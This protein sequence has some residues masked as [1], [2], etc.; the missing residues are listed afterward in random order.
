[1]EARLY[2]VQTQ[3][4]YT[5]LTKSAYSYICQWKLGFIVCRHSTIIQL[6]VCIQL[7]MPMEVWFY[8]VQ[9]RYHLLRHGLLGELFQLI[10]VLLDAILG[11]VLRRCLQA[12]FPEFG[13]QTLKAQLFW[14]RD[15]CYSDLVCIITGFFIF[16]AAANKW[17]ISILFPLQT[18]LSAYWCH[19]IEVPCQNC[20]LGCKRNMLL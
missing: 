17:G 10:V 20:L 15:C 14:K 12:P 3:Y 11:A 16:F 2:S 19:E 9:T 1:M 4:D 8:S 13:C 18:G 7:H 6:Y 5:T